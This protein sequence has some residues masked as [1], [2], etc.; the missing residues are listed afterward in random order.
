MKTAIRLGQRVV[1]ISGAIK[2]NYVP[3]GEDVSK[4][5]RSASARLGDQLRKPV[6]YFQWGRMPRGWELSFVSKMKSVESLG[7]P[8]TEVLQTDLPLVMGE[9]PSGVLLRWI[10]RKGRSDPKTFAKAVSVMFGGSAKRII[11]GLEASLNPEKMLDAHKE[12]EEPFQSVIDAIQR[13]DAEK[14][15]QDEQTPRKQQR[16]SHA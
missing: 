7:I 1:V 13:A 6:L 9:A 5:G 12:P 3:N 4:M 15:E 16:T 10:G 2:E 14:S 8:F 11:T